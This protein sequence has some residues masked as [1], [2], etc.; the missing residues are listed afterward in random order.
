MTKKKTAAPDQGPFLSAAAVCQYIL[1]ETDGVSSLIRI[2]DQFTVRGSAREM[3]PGAIEFSML[4]AFKNGDYAGT[5]TLGISV[6]NP[7]GSTSEWMSQK[8]EFKGNRH[9]GSNV[10]MQT[11]MGVKGPGRYH[12][13]VFLDQERVT[14]IPIF[15]LYEQVPAEG[16]KTRGAKRSKK[17]KTK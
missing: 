16:E 15:V 5:K 9:G 17:K 10:M 3:E 12:F 1:R 8:M 2:V 13:D 11:A 14:Q 4:I 7:E 6:T